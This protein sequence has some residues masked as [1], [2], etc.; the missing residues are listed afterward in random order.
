MEIEG[1]ELPN[2][3]IEFLR[4]NYNSYS[5]YGTPMFYVEY[6]NIRNCR[7]DEFEV[8]FANGTVIEFDRDGKLK[9]IDCGNNDIV[10]LSIIPSNI[11]NALR[12]YTRNFNIVEY[13][14]DRGRLTIEYEIELNN[15]IEF[16]FNKNGKLKE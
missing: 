9:S 11:K 1:Y 5:K 12:R 3:S 15:G 4:D 14:I 10:P 7:V 8:H 2:N 16:K 13:S 6:D